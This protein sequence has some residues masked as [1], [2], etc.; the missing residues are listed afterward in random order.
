MTSVHVYVAYL[1]YDIGFTALDGVRRLDLRKW[2][3]NLASHGLCFV[4]S[5]LPHSV[6]PSSTFV[7]V[8][9]DTYTS[10]F[11]FTL[12]SNGSIILQANE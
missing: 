10:G 4:S 8:D 1:I 6:V 9:A 2:Q 5:S 12:R 7:G 3:L 11:L